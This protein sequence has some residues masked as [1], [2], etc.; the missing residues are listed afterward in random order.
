MTLCFGEGALE[1][2]VNVIQLCFAGA[3]Q[4]KIKVA[5]GAAHGGN[6]T[7]IDCYSFVAECFAVGPIVAK[8]NIFD[9]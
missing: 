4:A 7:Q 8:M 6:V 5:R 1:K 9:E 2:R 3:G